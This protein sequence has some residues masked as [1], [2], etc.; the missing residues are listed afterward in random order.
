MSSIG[1]VVIGRN[2]QPRLERCLSS[3]VREQV[4]V[5]YVDSASS[6]GSVALATRLGVEVVA[7]DAAE[8]L[9]AARARNAGFFELLERSPN[10]D[11]VQFL[12]G[13]SELCPGWLDAGKRALNAAPN[14]A[15]VCG[16]L[17]ERDAEAS[18]YNRL[19]ELEWARAAGEVEWTGGMVMMRAR[20]FVRAHGFDPTLIAGEEPDLCSRLRTAGWSIVCI[21]ADM[22]L[23][24]AAMTHFSQW[25]QRNVRAGYAYAEAK[26][27][28]PER[29][30]MDAARHVRSIAF[31]GL[32]LPGAAVAWALPTLGASLA[33]PLGGYA[34]LSLRVY[35][36][37]RGQGLPRDDAALYAAFCALGKLPQ[38]QGLARYELLR[39]SGKSSG[40]IEHKG[41]A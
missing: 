1:C 35:R 39:L 22:A 33:L 31:W 36:S 4:P 18:L 11:Y 26:H 14:V 38:A 9:S 29:P 21:D 24:D 34:A 3:V 5:V 23:H 30:A 17:H 13:D 25:W 27:R 6:D 20:A 16:R 8:R 28:W 12:D 19:C 15:A 10:V 2:E 40:L 7:L 41:A 32:A 37:K